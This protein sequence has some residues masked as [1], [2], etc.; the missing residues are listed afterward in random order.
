[1]LTHPYMRRRKEHT[2]AMNAT[3][4]GNTKVFWNEEEKR[5]VARE[6]YKLLSANKSMNRV[7]AIAAAQ[8][9]LPAERRR[10]VLDVS[11]GKFRPWIEPLWHEIGAQEEARKNAADLF[12]TPAVNDS[13]NEVLPVSTQAVESPTVVNDAAHDD[14]TGS[15][16]RWT[17]DEKRKLAARVH[18]LT[19]HFENMSKLEALRKAIDSELPA[20]RAR[21]IITWSMVG[22]WLDPM[23][24]QIKIEAEIK[25]HEETED[26]EAR[27]RAER[28]QQDKE[29]ADLIAFNERVEAE[30]QARVS[31]IVSQHQATQANQGLES[32]IKLFADKLAATVVE[33][34]STALGKAV[35]DQMAS[36]NMGA[37]QSL[38]NPAERKVEAPKDHL[39]K[40][41]V[42]G[43]LN[44]QAEDVRKAFLGTV[45]F[46]FVKSQMEGGSGHGGAGMLTKGASSDIVV[47]M[48]DHIGKDVE[49]SAC[50][51]KV[52]YQ[53]LNGSVTSLKRWLTGWL[54]GEYQAGGS[55]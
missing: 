42:V 13:S 46:V 54:A 8:R 37:I 1:M 33:S 34:I 39:P 41:T 26:R 29:L 16:V 21:D 7:D 40:V 28:E 32:I 6:S 11:F 19:N 4:S 35:S 48:V 44:Q 22:A 20:D 51:L 5:K 10:A 38:T 47:A 25:Q 49:A 17:D 23:L 52:P 2:E 30:V 43:L 53:R 15:L 18:Y 27:L 9:V 14:H 45:E 31:G 24:E 12:Q 50:H 3:A 36:F 55:Q